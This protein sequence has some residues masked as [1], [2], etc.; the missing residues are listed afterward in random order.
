MIYI[1]IIILLIM[2]LIVPIAFVFTSVLDNKED[3]NNA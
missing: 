3:N 2:F 1:I